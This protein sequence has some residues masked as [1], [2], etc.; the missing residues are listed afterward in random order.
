MQAMEEKMNF[1][2]FASARF[3]YRC[4]YDAHVRN[5]RD[6]IF[7]AHVCARFHHFLLATSQF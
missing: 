1:N 3:V 5:T 6:S 2:H 4:A 7:V